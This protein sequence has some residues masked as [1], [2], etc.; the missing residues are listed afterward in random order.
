MSM[1]RSSSA[2][3]LRLSSHRLFSSNAFKPRRRPNA[4]YRPIVPK[5]MHLMHPNALTTN[6]PNTVK[7]ENSVE[8]DF[9]D[10]LEESI[11]EKERQQR[12]GGGVSAEEYLRMADFM[13]AE[14]G[15]LEHL[16]GQRR[17]LGL[18][19]WD[20]EDRDKFEID[21]D[22]FLEKKRLAAYS[23]HSLAESES[24]YVK[25]VVEDGNFQLDEDGEPLDPNRLAYGTWYVFY[26]LLFSSPESFCTRSL[27]FYL[28]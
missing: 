15:S 27:I 24:Q 3:T 17:A 26:S 2:F 4:L 19:Q 28:P 21:V 1:I 14:E 23:E 16:Q 18:E 13:T 10:W 5:G 25:N 9:Q 22:E 6:A 12:L 20:E 8:D 7:D 11:K